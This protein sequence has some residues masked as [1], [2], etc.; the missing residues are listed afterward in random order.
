MLRWLILSLFITLTYGQTHREAVE[1]SVHG[2]TLAERMKELNV[3]G[4][5]MAVISDYKIE[6]AKGYGLADVEKALPVGTDT[7]FQAGS[8]SKPVAAVAAM[9][10]VEQ[11]KLSLDEDVNAK[12]KSWKVPE[13]EFTIAEKVTLRRILSHSAGL[14]VHG[15]PG[16]VS[17]VPIPAVPEILDGKPPAN[18]AAVRVDLIPGTQFRYSG[19]GYTIAQLLMQDVTGLPFAAMMRDFVLLKAGMTRSTYEQPLPASLSGQAATGYVHEK[20][21][22][23]RYHT[24]PEMAA[25]GL[26]S[27]P[28]D[29]A[30][31]TIEIGKS[32]EGRSNRILLRASVDRML[33][34]EQKPY[35]LGFALDGTRFA[36]GGVDEGF[37]SELMSTRDGHGAVV[38]TNSDHGGQLAQEIIEAI[39]AVYQWP[40]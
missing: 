38:M 40:K 4:V 15:F 29:L 14:T 21:V 28:S 3:A 27:T 19:G 17:G 34:E 26:W 1:H 12:L 13:N 6:W 32:M 20:P 36:H 8:I 11:G 22:P 31:F 5:S 23:G 18:T 25:A 10:L 37:Q 2:V 7:L 30:R 9:K 35:G 24:Y 39:A 33:R 16:Y